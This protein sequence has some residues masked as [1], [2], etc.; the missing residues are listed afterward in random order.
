MTR[1]IALIADL[2]PHGARARALARVLCG[3]FDVFAQCDAQGPR[4]W[5]PSP[6]SGQYDFSGSP[7][8]LDACDVL[9]AHAG[10]EWQLLVGQRIVVPVVFE[11][12]G[13]G[14][15]S[16]CRQDPMLGASGPR[17]VVGV[18]T[19]FAG[20]EECP[21][22]PADIPDLE[23]YLQS[24]GSAPEAIP[25]FC[26]PR[27]AHL[28]P[29][30]LARSIFV[31]LLTYLE[32]R[33]EEFPTDAPRDP[34]GLPDAV[35]A[36]IARVRHVVGTRSWWRQSVDCSELAA[37]EFLASPEVSVVGMLHQS[38]ELVRRLRMSP[39]GDAE[40]LFDQRLTAARL[41]TELSSVPWLR[42]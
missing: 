15:P 9:F 37:D 29:R 17:V 41:F 20:P 8:V 28:G 6:S 40:P 13:A 18:A 11:Y 26:S 16:S 39:T 34:E 5:Q 3:A 22:R 4:K 23:R 1:R 24:R 27:D 35:V 14:R 19:P 32:A 42:A 33:P 21:I 36:W 25:D 31:T 38:A 10:D 2:K 12:S 7:I 30:S